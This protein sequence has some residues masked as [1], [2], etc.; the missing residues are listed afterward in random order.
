[1]QFNRR[2]GSNGGT[3]LSPLQQKKTIAA[4]AF[5]NGKSYISLPRLSEP[6]GTCFAEFLQR[7]RN[8][9]HC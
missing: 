2:Y 3:G 9:S 1:M 7:T 8:A 5:K 4:K 6:D